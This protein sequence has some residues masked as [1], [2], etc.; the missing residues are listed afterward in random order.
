MKDR[1]QIRKWIL[2]DLEALP[3][4]NLGKDAARYYLKMKFPDVPLGIT[5]HMEKKN[6]LRWFLFILWEAVTRK[7][8]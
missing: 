6:G 1:K 5:I 2:E 3:D 7:L 8:S 4:Y